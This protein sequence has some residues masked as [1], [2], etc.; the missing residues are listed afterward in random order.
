MAKKKTRKRVVVRRGSP[1]LSVIM[2][3]YN[4]GE[5]IHANLREVEKRLAAQKLDFEIVVVD[6][7]S[8]DNTFAEC[9]RRAKQSKRVRA[10]RLK[11]NAGKGQAL[12]RG[13]AVSRGEL[14][15]FLDADL[16][17]PPQ[18]LGDYIR[19]MERYDAELVIGAKM[20]PES[21]LVYPLHRR[22]VSRV[23]FFLVMLLFALPLRDTQTGIKLFRRRVL[24]RVFPAMMVKR[25]AF[26]LELLVLANYLGYRIIQAPVQLVSRRPMGR[27]KWRD[28]YVTGND[29]LA[30]FYRLRIKRY[31]QKKLGVRKERE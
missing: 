16:D 1:A 28:Y 12:R 9:R 15:A 17:L 3:A 22:L 8:A 23:Y 13:F 25:Y 18:Q 14:V 7:G 20:H 11:Q 4:E 30:V 26:D 6:D 29:T 21:K 5:R 10:V 24:E 31:Y 2:P 27:I 19:R